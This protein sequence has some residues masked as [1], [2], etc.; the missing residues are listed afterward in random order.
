MVFRSYKFF[1]FSIL[2]LGIDCIKIATAQNHNIVLIIAD[3]LGVDAL[4]GFG[5]EGNHATT[6][7]RPTS[8]ILGESG[9]CEL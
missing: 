1:L 9:L 7:Q 8:M 3:D 4:N 5:M 6:R 2:M